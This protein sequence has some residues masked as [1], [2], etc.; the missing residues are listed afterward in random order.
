MENSTTENPY[1][2]ARREWNERYGQFV[3]SADFWRK[4]ALW[5]LLLLSLAV[6]GVVYI[7]SQ[8]KLV[9]YIMKEDGT[10]RITGLGFP[11]AQAIDDRVIRAN[12]SEW[13]GW[14]RSVITDAVVQRQ[15]VDKAY[16]F[17]LQGT[18]A[19]NTLDQ[20]YINGHDP[21]V[22]MQ[23]GTVNVQVQSVLSLTDK[24]YQ[25]EWVETLFN[26]QGQSLV[27]EKYRALI[28]IEL[29]EV[30]GASLLKNPLGI[31]FQSISIQ[32]IGG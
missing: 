13:I 16:A 19:K 18:A 2:S 5:C 1:V 32:Q 10:G 23:S 17:I 7:G 30:D 25:I 15:Y 28:S 20:W 27:E 9:P 21:F 6:G 31:F 24:T 3:S 26:K 22:R 4:I 29:R 11:G 12:L 8:S 14:H